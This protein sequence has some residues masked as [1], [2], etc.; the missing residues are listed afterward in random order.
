MTRFDLRA[1]VALAALG[2][3]VGACSQ[4]AEPV[5]EENE[6]ANSLEGS[7]S[8]TGRAIILAGGDGASLG[9]VEVKEDADGV[10]IM[11][12]ASGIASGVHGI[13]LHE[14]GLCEGPKFES[15]GAH[16]NP[17]RR[18]H[19][20]DNPQGAHLGDL[21]NLEVPASGAGLASFTIPGTAI[22]GSAT[23]LADADGTSIIVHAKAD[24][25]KTDPSG[26]SGD[27]IACAV[28]AAAK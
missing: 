16:W 6:V 22:D 14:K 9:R 18:K 28:V 8:A 10:A 24:D 7:A 4:E 1:L 5:N 11:V 19:G 3:I 17:S 13:H 25:Y 15:A 2:T 26:D 21:I 23:A 27:R 20:R 12:A